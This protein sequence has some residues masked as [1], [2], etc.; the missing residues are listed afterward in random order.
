MT[1]APGIDLL[2]QVFERAIVVHTL[3]GGTMADRL[4]LSAKGLESFEK[5]RSQFARD[6]RVLSATG[7]RSLQPL[8]ELTQD[9][10]RDYDEG[11]SHGFK[12][13]G[14]QV[15]P[16]DGM[17]WSAQAVDAA[18]QDAAPQ[19]GL[20]HLKGELGG[21][22]LPELAEIIPMRR[23][24]ATAQKHGLLTSVKLVGKRLYALVIVGALAIGAAGTALT[25]AISQQGLSAATLTWPFLGISVVTAGLALLSQLM[26]SALNPDSPSSRLAR[27]AEDISNASKREKP[28][29][30]YLS[31]TD[32]LVARLRYFATFR[33]LIVDD[34]TRLDNLTRKVLETYLKS[35]ADASRDELWVLFYATDDKWLEL[36]VNRSERIKSKP[37]GYRHTRLFSLEHLSAAKRRELAEENGTPERAGYLTVGAIVRDTSG[38]SSMVELFQQEYDARK[39]PVGQART[40]DMLDFFHIFALNAIPSQNP[41][42]HKPTIRTVFSQRRKYRTQLLEALMPGCDLSKTSIGGYL[43]LMSDTFFPLAGETSGSVHN[44]SFLVAPEAGEELTDSWRTFD[45]ADPAM[46]HLFWTL[47]WTDVELHGALNIG[48]LPKI[49][50]HILRSATPAELKG[51]LGGQKA[52]ISAFTNDFFDMVTEVL[53]ACLRTCVLSDVP[54][55]LDYLLRLTE[56]DNAQ[57]E[58]RRRARL[59]PLAWRAYGLL[60]DERLLAVIL[61]LQPLTAQQR[62]PA[63]HKRDLTY[64]FLQSMTSTDRQARELMRSELTRAGKHASVY[65]LS[66]AGWLA[67]SVAPFLLQGSPTLTAAAA[68]A[69]GRLPGIVTE[70]IA[71]LESV[72]D[73]E[74]R[75]TDI[76]NVVLGV[77]SLT[78]ASDNTRAN[79]FLKWEYSEDLASKTVDSLLHACVLG[80]DL[81]QQRRSADP[82]A[83]T[84]DLVLDC[85]AEELLVVLLAAGVLL[86]VRWPASAWNEKVS[87]ANAVEVV[88]ECAHALGLDGQTMPSADEAPSRDLIR[89]ISRRMTMLTVLWRRLGFSQQGSFMA[90]RQAQFMALSYS[91]NAGLAESV[92]ELLPG[93]L[94]QADH[95]GLFAHLA[96][97]E[98]GQVSMELTAQLLARGS[99]VSVKGGFGDR[100][101]AELCLGAVRSGHTYTIDF[102]QALDF[103][104]ACWSDGDMRRLDTLLADFS[105]EDMPFIVNEL[106][107]TVQREESDRPDRVQDALEQRMVGIEDSDIERKVRAQFRTFALRRHMAAKQPI[108]ASAELDEWQDMRDLADYAFA[109]HLLLPIMPREAKDHAMQEAM[110]VLRDLKYVGSSGYVFLAAQVVRRLQP[111]KNGESTDFTAAVFALKAGFLSWEK[112]LRADT[113]VDILRLLMRY[114][115]ESANAY[116]AKYI[117]WRKVALELDE[118]QRLPELVDQGRFFLLIWHYF[119]FFADF[120]IPSDPPMDPFGLDDKESVAA[121]K[122]WQADGR[123]TPDAIVGSGKGMRLSGVF[124]RRGYALFFPTTQQDAPQVAS[125]KAIEAGRREFDSKAKDAIN[126]VYGMLRVLPQIPRSFEQILKRHEEFVLSRMGDLEYSQ[127][128]D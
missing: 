2:A 49:C 103:L 46:V 17:S 37:Y 111:A 24:A 87:R 57:V 45:L 104:L 53:R 60:G 58:R 21:G 31:F 69:R 11:R 61:E 120:S 13:L 6:V 123:A 101:A 89:D 55:L 54:A 43:R 41:W 127:P 121:L 44:G 77:W 119:Q 50:A 29:D 32:D 39:P 124:L 19:V 72:T 67:V 27:A 92:L 105:A 84:L 36:P 40:G 91:Q 112:R 98:C 52:F 15:A 5:Y 125:E 12:C 81:S 122:E 94:D 128:G 116:A 25:A 113:N 90:I 78:L 106:L 80:T 73:Q 107:N 117:E 114:D 1:R 18:I 47:Y 42:M 71:S 99:Q 86:L 64:L 108:D 68:D 65:A 96:A 8:E 93:E 62:S 110:G 66:R 59:R 10:V 56:D 76:L 26:M 109:L 100:L 70:S 115:S 118:T 75:T 48:V 23:I 97:A 95:I 38:L 22:T 7:G 30:A 74:W 85:L 102:S 16:G 34:F 79:S 51:R 20:L 33:C 63:P 3:F 28:S 83:D 126:S 88:S 82:S 4:F 9:Q 14:I 35:Y